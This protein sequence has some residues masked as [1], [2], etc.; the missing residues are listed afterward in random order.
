MQAQD[1][2]Q[3]I[4]DIESAADKAMDALK[5]GKADPQLQQSVQAL[6]QLSR[7]KRELNDEAQLKQAAIEIEQCADKAMDACKS[8]GQVDPALQQAIKD[9]HQ[10]ASTLKHQV[11]GQPT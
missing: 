8:A 7:T 10:K 1:I 9:A 6:H 4:N 11:Q 3:A 5:N 2:K